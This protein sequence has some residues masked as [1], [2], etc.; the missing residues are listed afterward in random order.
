MEIL[1]SGKDKVKKICETLKKQT[2]DPAK[3]EAKTIV[4]HAVKEAEKIIKQAREEAK[5]ILEDQKQRIQKEKNAFHS[6]LSFASR[7]TVEALKEEIEN[8]LFNKQISQLFKEHT[9]KEDVVAE[10]IDVVVKALDKE[11]LNAPFDVYIPKVLS[12]QKIA[13]KLTGQILQQIEGKEIQFGDFHGG[14][15]VKV[16]NKHLTVE[17]TE[18]SLKSLFMRF[19]REEFRTVLFET[20]QAEQA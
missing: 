19:I 9:A 18:D 15:K 2:L 7:Q 14:A 4:D 12:R 17:M 6:S 1:D 13:E 5:G 10:F 3:Q 8:H 16:K 11:G 20:K